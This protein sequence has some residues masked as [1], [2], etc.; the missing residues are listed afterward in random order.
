M[1]HLITLTASAA[2]FISGALLF[3]TP[4][5][6]APLADTKITLDCAEAFLAQG[7]TSGAINALTTSPRP[8]KSLSADW[9]Y[10]LALAYHQQGD[11][12]EAR[13]HLETA[14][15]ANPAH[16]PAAEMMRDYLRYGPQAK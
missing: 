8:A 16:A 7:D 10:T 11:L 13:D 2:A 5:P 1:P 9:D 15:R 14:L 3:E 12:N 4:T 6:S